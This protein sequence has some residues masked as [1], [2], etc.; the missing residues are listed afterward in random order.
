MKGRLSVSEAKGKLSVGKKWKSGEG[1][2]MDEEASRG[3]VINEEN[4]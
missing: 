3:K 2:G 4:G 1:K